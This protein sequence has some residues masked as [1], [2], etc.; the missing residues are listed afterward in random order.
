MAF[1]VVT[2]VR[3]VHVYHVH[4]V[5]SAG[6]PQ[7]APQHRP[8][9]TPASVAASHLAGARMAQGRAEAHGA[10]SLPVTALQGR[11]VLKTL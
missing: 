6:S 4:R 5:A 3:C 10:S 1:R 9:Q 11:A 8:P 7:C 2:L